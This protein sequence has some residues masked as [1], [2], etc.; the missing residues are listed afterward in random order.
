MARKPYRPQLGDSKDNA[1]R[2]ARR[3]REAALAE[4]DRQEKAGL[5]SAAEAAA[6]RSVQS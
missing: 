6:M 1:S 5:I 2:D 4:I 3:Q